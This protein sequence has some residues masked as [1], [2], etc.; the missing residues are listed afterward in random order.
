MFAKGSILGQSRPTDTSTATLFTATVPTEITSIAVC[1]TSGA[2]ATCR[3]HHDQNGTTYATGNALYYDKSIGAND[4]LWI[5]SG[6]LGSGLHLEANDSIGIQTGTA[7]TLTFTMY[8]I[9]AD[10]SKPVGH[11]NG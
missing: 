1:N 10:M 5:D 7:D 6:G 3:I 11:N 2:P 4:T 8:G 9:T